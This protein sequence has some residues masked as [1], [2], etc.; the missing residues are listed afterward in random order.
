MK[1]R[2]SGSPQEERLTPAPPAGWFAQV[3][4]KR[5]LRRQVGVA[6]LLIVVLLAVLVVL[7]SRNSP[8][9][10]ALPAGPQFTQPVPVRKVLPPSNL[11]EPPAEP[12]PV[13]SAVPS[14]AAPQASGAALDKSLPALAA[15]SPAS[16]SSAVAAVAEEAAPA[17]DPSAAA[18]H[19]PAGH[20]VQSGPLPDLR[21]AEELQAT[22]AAEGIPA[23]IVARLQVGPF[24]TR[25]DAEAARRKMKA[26]GIEGPIVVIR[27]SRP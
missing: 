17:V 23:S 4:L 15:A 20:V 13:V 27:V 25:A 16:H 1:T 3:D 5:Q 26:L 7:D 6:A 2:P 9:E 14:V 8:D 22:L 24:R 19:P 11:T 18:P 10:E 21:R 12:L